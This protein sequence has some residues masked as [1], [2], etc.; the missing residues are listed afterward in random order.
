MEEIKVFKQMDM[1]LK[2][3]S[4]YDPEI[5]DLDQWDEYIYTMRK[6]KVSS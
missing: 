6:Q 3:N 5:L 1:V 2:I 4:S